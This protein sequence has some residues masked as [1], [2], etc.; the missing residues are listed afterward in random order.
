MN[1]SRLLLYVGNQST[2]SNSK[3]VKIYSLESDSVSNYL[4]ISLIAEKHKIAGLEFT[5]IHFDEL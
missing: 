5:K 2:S 4:I 3:Y 1:S